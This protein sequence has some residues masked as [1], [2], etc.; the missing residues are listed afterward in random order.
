MGGEVQGRLPHRRTT[1]AKPAVGTIGGRHAWGRLAMPPY[2][3]I[4]PADVAIVYAVCCASERQN[5]ARLYPRR[6]NFL[7]EGVIYVF[8]KDRFVLAIFMVFLQCCARYFIVCAR[9]S[10]ILQVILPYF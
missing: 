6:I 10:T 5:I 9:K 1:W 2:Q 3:S 7:S 4:P 8:A